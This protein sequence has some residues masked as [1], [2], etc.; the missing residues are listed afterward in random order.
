[1]GK[2]KC[3]ASIIKNRESVNQDLEWDEFSYIHGWGNGYVGVKKDH[4]LYGKHYQD[5]ISIDVSTVT[6]NG[7]SISAF[8]YGLDENRDDSKLPID[9]AID[10]HCGITFSDHFSKLRGRNDDEI[11]KDE[12]EGE[13]YWY[14]GFDTH[15]SEDSCSNWSKEAVIKETEKL[16]EIL[17]NWDEKNC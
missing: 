4:P 17:E 1:M 3:S 6:Y 11:I 8:C 15:H 5:L 14:F 9:L 13:E 10:V 16:L 2:Y 12:E 7:N